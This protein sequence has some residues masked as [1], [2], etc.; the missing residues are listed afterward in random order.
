MSIT[1]L[2][3][4]VS[5]GN[6]DNGTYCAPLPCQV[7]RLDMERSSAIELLQDPKYSNISLYQFMTW[8]PHAEMKDLMYNEVVCIGYVYNQDDMPEPV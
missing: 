6:L 7:L 5:C 8:N 4:G 1:G 2:N 3:N